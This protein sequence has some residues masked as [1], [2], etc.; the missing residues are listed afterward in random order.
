VSARVLIVG[1]GPIGIE[2]HVA[3]RAAG[4]E[5]IHCERGALAET[6]TRFP[7]RMHF[8]SSNDRLG[9]AGI[10]VQTVDQQ[11]ATRE[12]YLAYLRQVVG[13]HGLPIRCFETVEGIDSGDGAF[14]VRTRHRGT[15]HRHEVDKVVLAVGDLDRPHRLEV[16][17]EDLPHVDHGFDEPEGY[18]GCAVAIVGGRNSAAEAA[19]RCQA[20]GARVTL[21]HRRGE[22]AKKAIKHWLLPELEGR[23]RRG[24]IAARLARTVRCFT[25][26]GC[27]LVATGEDG[28]PLPDGEIEPLACDRALVCTGFRAD[29]RLFVELGCELEGPERV[30]VVDRMTMQTTVPG[31]FVA[32]TAAAGDQSRYRLF[33]ENCHVH[34]GRIAAAITGGP[35]PPESNPYDL[36]ES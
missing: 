4:C 8:F 3:C 19:L 14:V 17:G 12:E 5:V 22:F 11:K 32:G 34:A 21:V 9:I 29:Q 2:T 10:P 31:V 24:E 35:P 28:A 33:I 25:P 23:I 27:E 36:P 15:V 7:R 1:A 30:P 18:A 26:E 20:V 13:R 16:P 6:I